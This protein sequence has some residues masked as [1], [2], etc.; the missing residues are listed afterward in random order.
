MRKIMIFN[1]MLLFI[2]FVGCGGEQPLDPESSGKVLFYVELAP[3]LVDKVAK[4]T[5]IVKAN[6][7]DGSPLVK[8]DLEIIDENKAIGEL[9][10]PAGKQRV[11]IVELRD[12]NDGLLAVS[13]PKLQ[14]VPAGGSITLDIRISFGETGTV[15]VNV[16]WDNGTALPPTA[17]VAIIITEPKPND[18]VVDKLKIKGKIDGI[19][20]RQE[21]ISKLK[22]TLLPG[23]E[24]KIFL[25]VWDPN[26]PHGPWEQPPASIAADGTWVEDDS[27][28]FGRKGM[29]IGVRFRIKAQLVKMKEAKVTPI[30][31]IVAEI[32]VIRK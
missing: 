32:D 10:I 2:I 17:A 24:L 20:D 8:Q 31:G 26:D 25:W 29:D 21:L 6:L 9:T 27:A 12:A 7:M 15:K 19:K 1:V 30:E 13:E 28:S 18:Q 5:V 23:E 11:F 3:A 4:V 22:I 14:D 16:I